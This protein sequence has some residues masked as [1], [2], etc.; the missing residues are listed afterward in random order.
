VE[1]GRGQ[2]L[3]VE[4]ARGPDG[5]HAFLQKKTRTE[6]G[7]DEKSTVYLHSMSR[8]QVMDMV[9]S[10]DKGRVIP[11]WQNGRLRPFRGFLLI[12]VE[13]IHA[14][15]RFSRV[16]RM[17][18]LDPKEPAPPPLWDI[19]AIEMTPDF[20]SYTGIE[21]IEDGIGGFFDYAQSWVLCP[22][23]ETLEGYHGSM[24]I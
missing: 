11:G 10:R 2:V 8:M 19:E 24:R 12:K 5:D 6:A 15:H 1:V 3:G 4:P 14:L 16:G 21:R 23:R 17:Y 22:A 18:M 7:G 13:H 20:W 9:R